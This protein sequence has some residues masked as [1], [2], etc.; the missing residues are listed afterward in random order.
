[1]QIR[2]VTHRSTIHHPIVCALPCPDLAPNC[3]VSMLQIK[4]T[5]MFS[6]SSRKHS[7]FSIAS[8][9]GMNIPTKSAISCSLVSRSSPAM[10]TVSL[11]NPV[12]IH[13]PALW[14]LLCTWLAELSWKGIVASGGDSLQSLLAGWAWSANLVWSDRRRYAGVEWEGPNASCAYCQYCHARHPEG[15]V[16]AEWPTRPPELSFTYIMCGR[17]SPKSR[18]LLP[19]SIQ[20]S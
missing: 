4:Q 11:R 14:F 19:S 8:R 1:M 17:Q 15:S 5:S 2:T 13:K 10:S 7:C 12:V 18:I 3:S 20:R 16:M 6:K 9:N